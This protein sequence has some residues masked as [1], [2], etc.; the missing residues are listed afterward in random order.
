MNQ[1]N[2]TNEPSPASAGSQPVAWRVY[3]DNGSEAVYSL[4]EQARAAADEWNWSVEPLYRQPQPTLTE[5]EREAVRR[6]IF[7]CNVSARA[8]RLSGMD[9]LADEDRKD[10]KT[11]SGL[12][13]NGPTHWMPM[14]PPPEV[15]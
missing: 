5:E 6:A 12:L 11:F 10:A 13:A 15:K 3:S 7:R 14:P 4:Y 9:D 8:R 1:P 2:D